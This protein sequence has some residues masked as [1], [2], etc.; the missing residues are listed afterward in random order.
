[1]IF[2][3]GARCRRL[4]SAKAGPLNRVV[5]SMGRLESRFLLNVIDEALV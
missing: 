5:A 2:V 4:A 1:M 3:T